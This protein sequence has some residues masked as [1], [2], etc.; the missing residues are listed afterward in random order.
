MHQNNQTVKK[1][2]RVKIHYKGSLTDGTVFDSSFQKKSPL[3]IQIE[4]LILG[5]EKALIGMRPGETK[6]VRLFPNEAYGDYQKNLITTLDRKRVPKQLTLKEG[7]QIQLE[8]GREDTTVILTNVT[9]DHITLDA[10]HPLA[11]KTLD[12]EIHLVEIL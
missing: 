7:M 12:F 6:Y 4:E 9:K 5:F 3:I 8:E 1:K 2:D 10:N 11:G